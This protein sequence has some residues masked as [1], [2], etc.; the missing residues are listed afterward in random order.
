MCI[1][2]P[3][4]AL[5]RELLLHDTSNSEDSAHLDVSAQGFW[6]DCHQLAFFDVRVFHPKCSL[7][8]TIAAMIS[9]PSL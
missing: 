9:I 8:S 7:L 4:Q 2:P 5:T 6:G 3:L 1:K